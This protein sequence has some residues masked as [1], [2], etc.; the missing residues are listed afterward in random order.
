[1]TN[2]VGAACKETH[3]RGHPTAPKATHLILRGTPLAAPLWSAGRSG[4][5]KG[6]CGEAPPAR[7]VGLCCALA[8]ALRPTVTGT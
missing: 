6:S 3:M 4:E 8:A 2:L 7:M 1:M 5:V